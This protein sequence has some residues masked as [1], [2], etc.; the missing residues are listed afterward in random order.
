MLSPKHENV[1]T[2]CRFTSLRPYVLAPL[3]PCALM[4]LHPYVCALMSCDLMSCALM[5]GFAIC[6]PHTVE[7]SH[8]PFNCWTSSRQAVITNFYS[9]WFDQF[10]KGQ[11]EAYA[12]CGRQVCRWQ[13]DSKTERSLC[14]LLAEATWWIKSNYIHVYG[15]PPI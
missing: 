10:L 13:L 1:S 9:V 8:C 15:T 3:C 4:S 5:S 6:L 7:A 12:V 2:A 14:C 11:C